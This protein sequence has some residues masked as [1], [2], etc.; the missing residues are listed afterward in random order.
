M[1]KIAKTQFETETRKFAEDKQVY[2]ILD[3]LMKKLIIN[4]P[5]NP[6]DFLIDS[7]SHKAPNFLCYIVSVDSNIDDIVNN[8]SLQQSLKRINVPAVIKNEMKNHTEIGKE[9][10]NDSNTS[11]VSTLQ[12]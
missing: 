6:I 4:K 2:D 1:D 9:L 3:K 7:L 5:A 8:V 10:V 12:V 11:E